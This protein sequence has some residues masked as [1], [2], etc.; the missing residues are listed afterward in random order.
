MPTHIVLSTGDIAWCVE[1]GRATHD[2]FKDLPGYYRNLLSSHVIG[3]FGELAVE[4]W[5][6]VEGAAVNRGPLVS[7]FRDIA[8]LRR[9]DLEYRF[10]TPLRIE[11]KTWNANFWE[12][13]GRCVQPRQLPKL[14][15]EADVVVWARLTEHATESL[16]EGRSP[17]PITVQ[18]IGYS[19]LE[20]VANAPLRNT[21]PHYKPIYNHQLDEQSIR[22][23]EEFTRSYLNV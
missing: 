20:D 21:G 15:R 6:R 9:C 11:V 4:N 16:V 10:P 2:R 1:A 23:T 7:H 3:K 19:T 14:R 8:E 5:L 22:P 18:I 13:W 12:A 17:V